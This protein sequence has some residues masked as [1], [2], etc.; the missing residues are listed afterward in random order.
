MMPRLLFV[1]LVAFLLPLGAC[2]STVDPPDEEEE[3][4]D[5]TAPLRA[6]DESAA[7][8]RYGDPAVDD[9]FGAA[10]WA[11]GSI[12]QTSEE[13]ATFGGYLTG[14]W[15]A[16]QQGGTTRANVA[17]YGYRTE[18]Q[19]DIYGNFTTACGG[20]TDGLF[21]LD[22]DTTY[23]DTDAWPRSLG[24]PTAAD[25]SP[26]VYGDRM[27]WGSFCPTSVPQRPYFDAPIQDLRVNTAMYAYD[28][29]DLEDVRFVRYE[30]TNTGSQ[31][32]SA[33]RVGYFSDTDSPAAVSDAVGFDPGTGLSYVYNLSKS[34]EDYFTTWVSGFAFL[35]T[36]NDAPLL[37]HRIMR[38]NNYYDPDFG[39][40]GVESSQ[41]LIDALDGLSNDG[42]PMIDPT[43]EMATRFAFTGDPFAGLGWRDGLFGGD[44]SYTGV[45][46]RH[47][48]SV[49]PIDLAPDETVT[50]TVVWVTAVESS[51]G[52][53]QFEVT[54][55][56]AAIR[57]DP[58][59]WRFSPE[60]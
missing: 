23:A 22:A 42:E 9:P 25:G 53:S 33:L 30:V 52:V 56:L 57:A 7:F 41:Q 46:V 40:T 48:T 6:Y 29:E 8:G 37:A 35:D 51:P 39:E 32:I 19:G 4:P 16:G 27:L 18:E 13:G 43:T 10:L 36:P 12:R 59:L 28:R 1:L 24:A 15:L 20:P 31:P 49:G 2:D 54:Q 11:D 14:L 26:R 55:T 50:F 3:V 21:A 38:K 58:S 5:R 44:G 45:D 60:S 47:L 17:W 34:G